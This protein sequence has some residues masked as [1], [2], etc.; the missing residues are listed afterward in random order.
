MVLT[1]CDNWRECG[2]EE[3]IIETGF[4]PPDDAE[5][6]IVVGLPAGGAAYTAIVSGANNT[7][8]VALVELYDLGQ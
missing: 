8:G 7:T 6:A 5:S 4:P 2:Q 3:Q 1:S